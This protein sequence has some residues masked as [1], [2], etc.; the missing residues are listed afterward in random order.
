MH[1]Q[2]F[3]ISYLMF[4]KLKGLEFILEIDN[5]EFLSVLF[6]IIRYNKVVL[7]QFTF[8]LLYFLFYFLYCIY[9]I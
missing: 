5:I 3:E 8:T 6:Y 9:F 2:F 7:F 1:I 4:G